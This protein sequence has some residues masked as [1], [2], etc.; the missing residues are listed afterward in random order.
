MANFI[1]Q[2]SYK[3]LLLSFVLML[4]VGALDQASAQEPPTSSSA[5]KTDGPV[6]VAQRALTLKGNQLKAAP[7]YVLK[8]GQRNRVLVAPAGGGGRAADGADC[9]CEGT[10]GPTPGGSCDVATSGDIATCSKST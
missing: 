9:V 10:A 6:S 5:M 8:K 3:S 2:A 1:R 7:G 4:M